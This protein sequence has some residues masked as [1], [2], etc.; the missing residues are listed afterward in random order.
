MM[1]HR[2]VCGTVKKV[3]VSSSGD[4]WYVFIQVE[5]EV[6]EP[7]VPTKVKALGGDLGVVHALVLS[8]GTVYDLPRMTD[9]DK[10]READ[11]H[12]QGE[13]DI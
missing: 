11:L 1:A 10:Q 2:P 4:H 12:K 6:N 13:I 9:L 7:C 5:C 3:T 8:D